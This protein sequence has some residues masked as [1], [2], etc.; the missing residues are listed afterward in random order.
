MYFISTASAV[1]WFVVWVWWF[2]FVV[3]AKMSKYMKHCPICPARFNSIYALHQHCVK[4]HPW[5]FI[6]CPICYE[7]LKYCVTSGRESVDDLV[8]HSNLVH[9][10]QTKKLSG[11]FSK[12]CQTQFNGR[13]EFDIYGFPDSNW[14][15]RSIQ[16]ISIRWA[17]DWWKSVCGMFDELQQPR[18]RI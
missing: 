6:C 3:R 1:N 14:G 16:E 4:E 15:L 8:M 12:F 2:R 5:E 9:D 13:L 10:R 7:P 17:N 11:V 18:D